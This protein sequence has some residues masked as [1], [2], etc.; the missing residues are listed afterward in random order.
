LQGTP[1][2]DAVAISRTAVEDVQH[3]R[4]SPSSLGIRGRFNFRDDLLPVNPANEG[5]IGSTRLP[6]LVTREIPCRTL[7]SARNELF[8]LGARPMK[9]WLTLEVPAEAHE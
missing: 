8:G 1:A 3:G 6:A 4:R 9:W 7:F 2:R 5:S